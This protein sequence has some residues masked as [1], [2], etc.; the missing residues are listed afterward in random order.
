MANLA[1]AMTSTHGHH[2]A[3]LARIYSEL[4]YIEK[5]QHYGKIAAAKGGFAD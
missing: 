1:I 2:Y 5:S 4:G 3:L